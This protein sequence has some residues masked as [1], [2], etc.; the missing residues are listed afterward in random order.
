M[1]ETKPKQKR[2]RR[3]LYSRAEV[4][5]LLK[6]QRESCALSITGNMSEYTARRVVKETP[7]VD[8]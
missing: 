7:L 1:E 8:F 4:T 3:I 2:Q 6:K 5:E